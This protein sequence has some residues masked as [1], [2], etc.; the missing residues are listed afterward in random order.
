MLSAAATIMR[1]GKMQGSPHNKAWQQ[2]YR[3]GMRA[4]TAKKRQGMQELPTCSRTP[5]RGCFTVA[6][7]SASAAH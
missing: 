5:S 6:T 2:L 3:V 7:E 4:K 1:K